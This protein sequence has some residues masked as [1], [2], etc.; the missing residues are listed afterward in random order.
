MVVDDSLGMIL[1]NLLIHIGDSPNPLRN[2]GSENCSCVDVHTFLGAFYVLDYFGTHIHQ[3]GILSH[4]IA[5]KQHNC[6]RRFL[7]AHQG[8]PNWR[9]CVH[10]EE[11][12]S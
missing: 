10:G 8:W 11:V 5:A 12:L 9:S 4:L 6:N 3:H 7:F 2:N 1:S